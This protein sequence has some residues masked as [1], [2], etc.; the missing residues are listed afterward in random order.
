MIIELYAAPS[1]GTVSPM[2]ESPV[3]NIRGELPDDEP[4]VDFGNLLGSFDS[5]E[6]AIEFVVKQL[7][8]Q[9]LTIT[10]QETGP[11]NEYTHIDWLTMTTAAGHSPASQQ[12]YYLISD[13][14]Y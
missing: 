7:T 5:R 6:E 1:T 10:Q 12:H 11:F 2:P 9:H 4:S 14:G 3:S 13:E 8:D